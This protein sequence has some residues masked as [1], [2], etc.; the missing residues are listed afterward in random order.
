MSP[1]R[2]EQNARRRLMWGGAVLALLVTSITLWL[3]LD[4]RDRAI[5]NWQQELA[6]FATLVAEVAE[7]G[8]QAID[9]AEREILDDM[10]QKE[11]GDATALAAYAQPP[12]LQIALQKRMALLPQDES[13]AI[14]DSNGIMV[15]LRAR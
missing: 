11:V 3:T 1:N 4:L 5:R 6:R 10:R 9:E 13:I 7:R 14:L 15:T 12:A 8:F 2:A